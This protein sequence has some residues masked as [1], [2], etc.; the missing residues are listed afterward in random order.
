VRGH[1]RLVAQA[2]VEALQQR[3]A[4]G[5]HDPAIHDV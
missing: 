5:E 3:A 2:L 1:L 4:A